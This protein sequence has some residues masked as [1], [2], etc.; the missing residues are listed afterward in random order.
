MF[1]N[2]SFILNLTLLYIFYL[3]HIEV[4]FSIIHQLNRKLI[5]M[6]IKE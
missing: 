3:T 1:C 2:S 6:H 5:M 4:S